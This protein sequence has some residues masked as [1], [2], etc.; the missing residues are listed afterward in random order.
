VVSVFVQAH[1][2]F[3]LA[4]LRWRA[5]HPNGEPPFGIGDFL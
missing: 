4:K 3:G 1:N 5:S 2:K